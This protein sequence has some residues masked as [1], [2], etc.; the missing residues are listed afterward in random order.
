LHKSGKHLGNARAAHSVEAD[1][2]RS[3]LELLNETMA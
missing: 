2:E 3:R 1:R